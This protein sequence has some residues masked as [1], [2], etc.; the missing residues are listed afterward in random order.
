LLL[1]V[2]IAACAPPQA[3]PRSVLDFME[4]GLAREGVL[5]RCNRNRDETLT[6]EECANA[7]RAAAT[8]ALENERARADGLA[9]ESE[10][11]LLALRQ[12]RERQTAAEQDAAAR[13]RA[14]TEAAYE[15]QWR[16][17]AGRR[18]ADGDAFGSSTPS[19]GV[20]LGPVMPSMT[21]ST[22]FDV[23]AEGAEPLGRP[24]LTI[25]AAEPPANDV[26]VLAPE[27]E[28]AELATI[29]RP[30]RTDAAPQ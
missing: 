8:I 15:A 17:P 21:E 2:A 29:P 26:L 24:H 6:D 22:L 30:F 3:E 16:D 12:R 25:A 9:R 5:T 19:F 20:P 14:A 28:L 11:K 23:Y 27:L 7:R 13:V 10:S 4:D 1:A 18:T